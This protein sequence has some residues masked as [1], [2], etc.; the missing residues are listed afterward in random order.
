MSYYA[1]LGAVGDVTFIDGHYADEELAKSA[2]G[3]WKKTYPNLDFDLCTT[4]GRS[5]P[6]ADELSF[7]SSP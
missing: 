7:F 5:W 2:F 4:K 3:C 6:I 1:I